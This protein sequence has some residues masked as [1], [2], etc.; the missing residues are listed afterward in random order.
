[1]FDVRERTGIDQTYVCIPWFSGWPIICE[2]SHIQ[3]LSQL[4]NTM[5][6]LLEHTYSMKII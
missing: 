1:M 6:M 4:A 3:N 5:L 2:Q